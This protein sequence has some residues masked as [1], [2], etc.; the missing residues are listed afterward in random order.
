MP[1]TE[2]VH[3]PYRKIYVR[4][5]IKLDLDDMIGM[6]SLLESASAYWADGVLFASF[7]M[8]ESEELAKREIQDD[9]MYLDKVVFSVC[10][11]YSKTVKSTTN[12]E[13][14][15]LNMEKSALYMEM[16]SWLKQQDAWSA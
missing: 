7:A 5:I 15:V 2:L 12:L 10:K 1:V 9:E 14:G 13:V 11:E 8:T 6:M 3:R 16:V 4:D